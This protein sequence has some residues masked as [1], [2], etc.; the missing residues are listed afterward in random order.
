VYDFFNPGG[1][2]A[3]GWIG[4][5]ATT[6]N[7]YG[8]IVVNDGATA[9]DLVNNNAT[10]GLIAYHELLHVLVGD[11]NASNFIDSLGDAVNNSLRANNCQ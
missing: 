6:F 2:K 1:Q 11:T 4:P 7:Q 5:V 10:W 9:A 3:S 8:I